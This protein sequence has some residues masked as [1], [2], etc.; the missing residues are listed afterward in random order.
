MIVF[1]CETLFFN[2]LLD[3]LKLPETDERVV[4]INDKL[5]RVTID[6]VKHPNRDKK[7]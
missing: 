5:F 6:L 1:S 3:K 4:T 7:R 2:M